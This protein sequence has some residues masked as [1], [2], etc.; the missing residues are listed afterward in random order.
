MKLLRFS[1]TL[2]YAG[3]VIFLT[4]CGSGGNEKPPATD[5]TAAAD[6]AAKAKAAANTIITTPENVA[7]VTHKVASF[8]K[9]LAAYEAHDSA[10]QAA[11]LHNYVIGRGLED[12]NMV[13]VALKVD[14]TAKAKA[15]AKDPGLKEAMKKGGVLGAPTIAIFTETWQDTA[16]LAPGTIRSQSTFMVKDWDTFVKSFEDGKQARTD[17]GIAARVV[18]H[19]LDDNKKASV[20][21]AILDSAKAFAYYKSDA[22]KQKRATAGVVGEPARFLFRIVKMN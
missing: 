17:N 14:D 12:S 10:R 20:V 5:S 13:L 1:G 2:F 15:F 11:G 21:T 7:V 8:S 4:S 16:T 3:A 9:W 6:S 22:F 19:D 18:G